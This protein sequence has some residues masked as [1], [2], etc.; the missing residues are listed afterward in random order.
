MKTQKQKHSALAAKVAELDRELLAWAR[1]V[2]AMRPGPEQ[3]EAIRLLAPLLISQFGPPPP[4]A[5]RRRATW[6]FSQWKADAI[7][8][9]TLARRYRDAG[10]ADLAR[11]AEKRAADSN[12]EAD[13][14]R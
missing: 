12:R 7:Q 9:A 10:R 1:E 3:E 14:L 5:P 13:K 8:Q 2:V 4:P 6:G 11:K